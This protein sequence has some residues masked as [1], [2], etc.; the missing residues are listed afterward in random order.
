MVVY[1]YF[2]SYVYSLKHWNN[3]EVILQIFDCIYSLSRNYKCM[4]RKNINSRRQLNEVRNLQNR[5]VINCNK[6]NRQTKAISINLAY[7]DHRYITSSI[8]INIEAQLKQFL[9]D[10][11]FILRTIL[12]L[13]I[14]IFFGNMEISKIEFRTFR[15]HTIICVRKSKP[16]NWVEYATLHR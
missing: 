5:L 10:R 15:W 2:C 3:K 6:I 9:V 7:G 11:Q 13:L 1:I 8:S 4:W 14:F 12:V 16:L